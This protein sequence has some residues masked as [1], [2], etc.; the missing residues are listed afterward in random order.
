MDF[1]F[2]IG[3]IS[4]Y[5]ETE[6]DIDYFLNAIDNQYTI[7]ELEDIFTVLYNGYGQIPKVFTLKD[8]LSYPVF[9]QKSEKLTYEK[10]RI[11]KFNDSSER[12]IFKKSIQPSSPVIRLNEEDF[13]DYY[14]KVKRSTFFNYH[15]FVGQL[16]FG[17]NK[18]K[19]ITKS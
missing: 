13:L 16:R 12:K 8:K 14:T 17:V 3:W 5:F 19:L 4:K 1:Y 10:E 2:N 6:H 15:L 9:E 7:E 11:E 18:I